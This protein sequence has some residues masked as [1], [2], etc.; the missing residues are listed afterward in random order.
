MLC[1]RAKNCFVLLFAQVLFPLFGQLDCKQEGES[2]V[3]ADSV[4]Y[5]VW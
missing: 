2:D 1:Q 4:N 5:S 3:P